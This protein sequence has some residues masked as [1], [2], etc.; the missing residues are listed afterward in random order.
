MRKL[1]LGLAAAAA[2][3]TPLAATAAN[4]ATTNPDGS[5]TVSKGD[6]QSAMHWSNDQF[7]KEAE[8]F[9]RDRERHRPGHR[10]HAP[11]RRASTRPPGGDRLDVPGPRLLAHAG[12]HRVEVPVPRVLLRAAGLAAGVLA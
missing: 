5:I 1:L 4:A 3:A 11:A 8:P 7:L 12:Q 6:V 9:V 2:I 10:L